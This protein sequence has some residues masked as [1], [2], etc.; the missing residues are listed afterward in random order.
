MDLKC[1]NCDKKHHEIDVSCEVYFALKSDARNI[2]E[3]HV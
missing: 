2:D 1:A 3:S